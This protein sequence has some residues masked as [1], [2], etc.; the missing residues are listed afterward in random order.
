M[1]NVLTYLQEPFQPYSE[2]K[3]VNAYLEQQPLQLEL[4]P[5]FS[6]GFNLRAVFRW[7]YWARIRQTVLRQHQYTCEICGHRSNKQLSDTELH[8][9]EAWTFDREK[10]TVK[11]VRLKCLCSTCHEFH[12]VGYMHVRS[13]NGEISE[14]RANEL[15]RHYIRINQSHPKAFLY[16]LFRTFD[17]FQTQEKLD[18]LAGL[19]EAKWLFEVDED[20]TCYYEIVANLRRQ[21]LLYEELN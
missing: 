3:E 7:D 11:L 9:H 5:T 6:H 15:L 2:N 16:D 18:H 19:H 8:V 10:H 13:R 12:H 1:A 14:Q 21:N 4:L 17:H 20:V